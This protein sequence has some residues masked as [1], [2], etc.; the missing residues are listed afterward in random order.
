[1]KNKTYTIEQPKLLPTININAK[2]KCLS[3][4]NDDG[5]YFEKDK[6]YNIRIE[7]KGNISL[8]TQSEYIYVLDIL[9]PNSRFSTSDFISK[10]S[11]L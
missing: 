1:M 8:E 9:A 10:F 7:F 5:F 4:F 11:I 3:S 6:I 2:A